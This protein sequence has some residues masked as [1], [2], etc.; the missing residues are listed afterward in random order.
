[1]TYPKLHQLIEESKCDVLL[2]GVRD[3]ESELRKQIK[4]EFRKDLPLHMACEHNAPTNVVLE[5]LVIYEAACRIPGRGGN[6]PLHIAC[7][8]NYAVEVIDEM[9]RAYPE[10]L[11]IPNAVK[12]TPRHIG[13]SDIIAFQSIRR[14]TC[15]WYQLKQDEKREEDQEERLSTLFDKVENALKTLEKSDSHIESMT[16]RMK[17][18]KES[19]ETIENAETAETKIV[20]SITSIKKNV[21]DGLERMN[22]NLMSIEDDI[23]SSSA[24]E[25]MARASVRAHQEQVLR[26]QKKTIENSKRLKRDFA[27]FRVSQTQQSNAE[28]EFSVMSDEYS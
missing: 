4:A 27:H 19:I 22:H 15:C 8:K 1:M 25:Y 10:A 26:L 7:S 18:A 5:L 14:P 12:A 11:D 3:K 17:E 6:L 13:H 9:I 23:Q 21:S 2:D 28:E 16:Q 20:A 24:R